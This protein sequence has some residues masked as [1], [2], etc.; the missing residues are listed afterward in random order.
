M[1]RGANVALS[2]SVAADSKILA[3]RLALAALIAVA[4]TLAAASLEAQPSTDRFFDG[5]LEIDLP[6]DWRHVLDG[7]A[8]APWDLTFRSEA[9]KGKITFIVWLPQRERGYIGSLESFVKEK[10]WNDQWRRTLKR[11]KVSGLDAVSFSERSTD[12]YPGKRV[13]VETH[14]TW[15]GVPE[16]KDR[17]TVFRFFT[18]VDASGPNRQA[19]LTAYEHMLASMRIDPVKLHER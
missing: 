14:E 3:R 10:L 19:I 16:L 18:T 2:E 12:P 5:G 9:T 6:G 15:I 8:A 13:T 17:G 1:E 7:G 11:R 4:T